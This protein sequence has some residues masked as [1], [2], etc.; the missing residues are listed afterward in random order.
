MLLAQLSVAPRH[1][2]LPILP[3]NLREHGGQ[4]FGPFHYRNNKLIRLHTRLQI[5]LEWKE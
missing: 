1:K 2:T 3:S 5:R 4:N